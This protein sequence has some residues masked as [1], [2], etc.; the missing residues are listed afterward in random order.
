VAKKD[1]KKAETH[2]E[3]GGYIRVFILA[4]C[5][6]KRLVQGLSFEV[7]QYLDI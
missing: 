6:T 7:F 5:C 2:W 3:E 4:A 1:M